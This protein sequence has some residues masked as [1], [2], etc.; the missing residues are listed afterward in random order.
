MKVLKV[1]GIILI[2]LFGIY[3]VIAAVAP[4]NLIVE[5]STTIDASSQAVS[6]HVNCLDKWP[7][8]SAWQAMDPKMENEYSDNPCGVGAWNSW[9]GPTSGKGK[10]TIE[11]VN[12][13]ESIK[14][15]LV[16]EGFEGVNYANWK[17]DEVD[18]STIVSWSFEGAP[19]PFFFR[20]INL[21]MKGVLEESYA[22]GLAS[23]KEVVESDSSVEDAS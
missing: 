1:L 9:N 16:F 13:S 23:L 3:V 2:T 19:S 10:Q 20:P 11:E 18:G 4:A 14:M 12:G 7:A 15:N 8:W 6:S 5:K 22:T 21:M 17:F